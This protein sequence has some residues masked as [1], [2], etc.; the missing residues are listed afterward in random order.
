MR[1]IATAIELMRTDK[2]FLLID[3]WDD[4]H[5]EA[6]ERCAGIFNGTCYRD[7]RGGTM[8]VLV[9]LTTPIAYISSIPLDPFPTRDAVFPGLVASDQYPPYTFIYIDEDPDIPGQD[10]G[11]YQFVGRYGILLELKENHYIL[12]GSGP[13]TVYQRTPYHLYD[14]SN[15]TISIGDIVYSSRTSF[16]G[17]GL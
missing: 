4:D 17:E 5:S 2:E 14:P 9:P 10:A 12:I 7:D 1:T 3:F 16:S 15:G 11:F 8:G 13:D 6:W